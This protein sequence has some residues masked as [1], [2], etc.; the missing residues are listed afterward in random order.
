M[1]SYLFNL[2]S[3]FWRF[4]YHKK[5]HIFL[6]TYGKLYSWKV[7]GWEY[8]SE[9]L[10]VYGN[11]IIKAY[12]VR[13]RRLQYA[14]L[15]RKS[16]RLD[17]FNWNFKFTSLEWEFFKMKQKCVVLC[18]VWEVWLKIN[19]IFEHNAYFKVAWCL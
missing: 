2:F 17:R 16:K 9:N 3:N 10:P 1:Q 19:S 11:H 4:C 13:Y 14:K 6:I 18:V 7:F 12:T 5:A 8:I 15:L